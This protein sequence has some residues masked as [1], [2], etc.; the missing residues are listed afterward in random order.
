[1]VKGGNDRYSTGEYYTGVLEEENDTW[2]AWF[3]ECAEQCFCVP[4]SQALALHCCT[5]RP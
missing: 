1:M 4:C 5:G 2:R 3:I